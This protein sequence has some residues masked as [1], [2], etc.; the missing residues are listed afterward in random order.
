MTAGP[1]YIVLACDE[2]YLRPTAVTIRSITAQPW[3][4]PPTI[5]VMHSGLPD[6]RVAMLRNWVGQ[7]EMVRVPPIKG[8]GRAVGARGARHVSEAMYLKIAVPDH[9]PVDAEKVLYLDSDTLVT[10]PVEE[11]FAT[12]LAG[13]CLGAVQDRFVNG[14][15]LPE[16]ERSDTGYFNSGVL[17]FDVE[18]ARRHELGERTLAYAE[19][20]YGTLPY[21]DQDA[22]NVAAA[23][24]WTPLE[25]RW[26]RMLGEGI[27][28]RGSAEQHNEM[29]GARIIHLPG[30]TKPW[31][32]D[33]P[34]GPILDEYMKHSASIPDPKR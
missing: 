5:M 7:V 22:L 8:S 11:L 33:F 18:A 29:S 6:N 30:P 34:A 15:H 9:S 12:D 1:F 23:D 27:K 13:K 4:S 21:P 16:I 3:S 24:C 19:R 32:D 10:G 2:A 14:T 31:S 20:K 17:L 28:A 26:N 25:S